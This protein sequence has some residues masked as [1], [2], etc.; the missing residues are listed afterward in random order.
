M[1]VM[2]ARGRRFTIALACALVAAGLATRAD[3]APALSTDA[4]AAEILDVR[5]GLPMAEWRSRVPGASWRPFRG[6]LAR[7][8]DGD[9]RGV[10]PSGFWCAVASD[11]RANVERVAV[12]FAIRRQAP[13]ACRVELVQQVVRGT[14]EQTAAIY[15]T[16]A[17][18]LSR[19]LGDR[20]AVELPGQ[21]VPYP[22]GGST[23]YPTDVGPWREGREWQWS[24]S[25]AR[26]RPP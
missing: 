22:W 24:R 7:L 21:D 9:D 3:Q 10:W 18:R 12:F 26:A 11:T 2:Q 5:L 15:E 25:T 14:P 13:L 17:D 23:G 4:L 19:T 20:S 8:I 16:L 6:E 1:T